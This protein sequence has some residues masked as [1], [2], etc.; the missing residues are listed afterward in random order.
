MR[1]GIGC[2][3][4]CH[5]MGEALVQCCKHPHITCREISSFGL[6]HQIKACLL[7]WNRSSFQPPKTMFSNAFQRISNNRKISHAAQRGPAES[8]TFHLHG[9]AK[10][11]VF[12]MISI[13]HWRDSWGRRGGPQRCLPWHLPSAVLKTLFSQCFL[14]DFE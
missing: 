14:K 9:R 13:G 2:K 5:V 7:F 10:T 4:E 12:P 11:I 1:L 3:R 8:T 6:N